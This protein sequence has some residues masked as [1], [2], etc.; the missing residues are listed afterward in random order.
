MVQAGNLE[1]KSEGV[2]RK[3]QVT[4]M[5]EGQQIPYKVEVPRNAE[6]ETGAPE[7][8]IA[9]YQQV[10]STWAN[11]AINDT[12]QRHLGTLAYKIKC[13]WENQVK[14]AGLRVGWVGVRRRARSRSCIGT[15]GHK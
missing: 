4:L 9:V 10:N 15:V 3:G 11:T 5:H 8:Q 13:K 6:V 7:Q 14:K 12:E 1:I 2:Y